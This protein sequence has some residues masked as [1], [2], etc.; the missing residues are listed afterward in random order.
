MKNITYYLFQS[1]AIDENNSLPTLIKV[2]KFNKKKQF[3]IWHR[4]VP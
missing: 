2:M 3:F 1:E 4:L